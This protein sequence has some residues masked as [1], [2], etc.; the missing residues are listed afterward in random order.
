M[1]IERKEI[2]KNGKLLNPAKI[3]YFITQA[4][5]ISRIGNVK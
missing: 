1:K 2:K 4:P 3:A 5:E